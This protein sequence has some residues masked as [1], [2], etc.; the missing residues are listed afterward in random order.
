MQN[1]RDTIY[2]ARVILEA[3][4]PLKIGNGSEN[5]LTD[6]TIGRDA[7]GLPY[8]PAT[9]IMGLIRHGIDEASANRIMGFEGKEGHGSFLSMSE[10]KLL[11]SN[12]KAVDGLKDPSEI[13]NDEFLKRFK[14]LPIRQHVKIS[15]K[16]TAEDGAK[17]DEEVIPKGTRFVFEFEL[18]S[19]DSEG[20]AD[21]ELLT[22]SLQSDLFRIGG[23]SRK[24]FGKIAI[25]DMRLSTLHL[26]NKADFDAWL[27][28]KSSLEAE[29]SHY[30]PIASKRS[31]ESEDSITRYEL[32]LVPDDF[33]LFSAGIADPETGIDLAVIR[34]PFIEW[35]NGRGHWHD[36][37]TSLV[38][39]ASSV[40]GALSH[41]TAY[42]YNRLCGIFSDGIYEKPNGN[43]AVE[44][45]FGT[46]GDA[47]GVGKKSGK[48]LF[49]DIVKESS[50]STH[51]F[52]HVM[53]DAL[54]GGAIAGALFDEA[55]LFAK[56]ETLTIEIIV[57]DSHNFSEN[58]LPAFEEALKDVC[59]GLLPFGG[60]VGRGNGRM[61][62]KLFKNGQTIYE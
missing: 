14:H 62:G 28:K 47:K 61:K 13:D 24:G 20:K 41:R 43:L 27:D 5:F 40:K 32:R 4:T 19:D 18:R 37:Q 16:G 55:P 21:F 10:G 51:P 52:N 12:G 6:S 34:E 44:E 29:W 8:L 7:N 31:N 3:L 9:T 59:L 56:D 57:L 38:I 11:D 15:H 60:G 17:F 23:G 46:T 35:T 53:I 49:S 2:L 39:P 45:L 25:R 26:D 50:A 48:A 58:V 36:R 22:T 33:L 42:H 1:K 30:S 54:T